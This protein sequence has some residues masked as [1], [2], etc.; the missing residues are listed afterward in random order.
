MSKYA[1]IMWDGKNLEVPS[2]MGCARADQ[3]QGTPLDNLTELA[4]RVCY[5]SLG[6]GRNSKDYHQHIADVGHG[7]VQEHANLTFAM[8]TDI[9]NFL[10]CCEAL[11]NRPGVWVSKVMPT[12]SVPGQAPLTLRITANLRAIREWDKFPPMNKMATLLGQGIQN[13]AKQHAPLVMQDIVT[14]DDPNCPLRVVEPMFEDEMWVTVFFT[15]VSRGFS[16][17][18]VRHKYRTAVSQRSTR[19]VDE[20]EAPWCWHPLILKHAEEAGEPYKNTLALLMQCEEV[21]KDAYGKTVAT[22]QQF[23]IDKGVD[24]FTARKQARGAARGVLGNALLTELVFSASLAE[25]KWIFE[26]RAS[27][28]ADAEI[29]VVMDEVYEQFSQR[30]PDNFKNYTTVGCPDGIGYSVVDAT[31]VDFGGQPS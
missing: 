24:K 23:M 10:M 31:P 28:H 19:Y 16:H 17:E 15:N 6:S 13:L 29:R 2:D 27:P 7:S 3:L 11:L 8:P 18:L 5:D 9:P 12:L 1:K 25:W 4:G 26:L 22:L 21:C 30:F 14:V 20:N